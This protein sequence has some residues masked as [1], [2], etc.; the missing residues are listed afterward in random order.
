MYD[1]HVVSH[2][3]WDREWYHTAGRFRQRLVEL[4]DDLINDPPAEGESFLLDGQTIVIEDYLAVRPERRDALGAL[5]AAGRLEAGPWYVLADELIPGGEALVRN[6]L[7]GTRVLRSFGCEPPPVL[8]CPDAFGHPAALP[9]LASGFGLELIVLWRG[10]GGARWPAGDTVWWRGAD[11]SRVLAFHLPPD[12]YELGAR[13]PAGPNEARER[14]QRLRNILI[15]R[16]ATKVLLVQNGA[17]H[18]ARQRQLREAL[19]RLRDAA[20]PDKAHASSL[21]AFAAAVVGRAAALPLPAVTGELRDSYGY[22]W[23][24]QGTF[25]T[26]AH[27]KRANAI[28]ERLLGRDAE[29]WCAFAWKKTGRSRAPLVRAAWKALLQAHPHDTLCGC[30]ID[31]VAGAMEARIA[32]ARTEGE[33]LRTDALYDVLGHDAVEAR[34]R[35]AH[36]PSAWKPHVLVRNRAARSRGGVALVEVQEFVADAPVGAASAAHVAAAP[37]VST[38]TSQASKGA[39][40]DKAAM[41][42]LSL[43]AQVLTQCFAYDRIESP[44]H[45]PDNDLV[46]V[47]RVV[48]WVPPVPA[49]GVIAIPLGHARPDAGEPPAGRSMPRGPFRPPGALLPEQEVRAS[50]R[51]LENELLG[52]D[53]DDEGRVGVRSA[54]GRIESL[55]LFEDRIDAGD[56]Y[57]PSI[58]GVAADARFAGVRLTHGGPL[59]GE[60]IA[61]WVFGRRPCNGERQAY[62]P[63]EEADGAP[64]RYAELDVRF[65]VDAG[66]PF[67]RVF[68]AGRNAGSDHRLR[69]GFRTGIENAAIWA[70]AAFGPVHRVPITAS[71]EDIKREAPLPTAPLHRYVSLFGNHRGATIYSDGL[72]EYEATADGDVLITLVRA[73]GQLSRNDL[74]ERPG[75]A[76]WPTPTPGAQCHGP[77][78]AE[79]A[80]FPHGRRDDAAVALIERTTD[81]VLLPLV[82]TTLRSALEPPP[83]FC[84]V[85]LKGEGLTLSAIKE[86]DDGA[87]LVLRCVNVLERPAAGAWRLGVPITQA[88]RAR[89]DETAEERL[90]VGPDGAVEFVA[91]ERE[92]VTVLVW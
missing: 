73:V 30:S 14:W 67:L 79:L 53:I 3:H 26:R 7:V 36:D 33:G 92:I 57:T 91:R 18:H 49:Y 10:Y 77:F 90:T 28:V 8:Y 58:R 81:D 61:R 83:P 12:G 65:V 59:R 55:L 88:W 48:A 44:Q 74:P 27:E 43:H 85:E 87:S 82:G 20:R 45:Y 31:E 60:L 16:S 24:L 62:E 35:K 78:E 2:T 70:D 66:A 89:L 50:E 54:H 71:A 39:S 9:Q 13:L 80:Y 19:E 37:L 22:T 25:G 76:G 41:R 42:L 5:L 84:G 69:I 6:L 1:V 51:T 68:V 32:D 21:G 86:S 72:A 4:I 38:M 56:L 23:T 11:G 46:V 29:P 47:S 75:H 63:L 64:Q 34:E 52:V 17:D 40:A 15:G